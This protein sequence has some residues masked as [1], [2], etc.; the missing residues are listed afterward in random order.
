MS[1]GI[2]ILLDDLLCFAAAMSVACLA[3]LLGAWLGPWVRVRRFPGWPPLQPAL[4]G[5]GAAAAMFVLSSVVLLRC[6]RAT[7][8]N[9]YG[10]IGLWR[11]LEHDDTS[12]GLHAFAQLQ[13][14]RSV[15]LFSAAAIASLTA[16]TISLVPSRPALGGARRYRFT[17]RSL[18][19]LLLAISVAL[20]LW[21]GARRQAI[22]GESAMSEWRLGS[23][24]TISLREMT[25]LTE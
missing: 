12:G 19:I 7:A 13:T 18:F 2:P 10:F 11:M 6:S 3:A 20:G 23:S 5:V 25:P 8:F 15:V 9:E 14:M 4:I 16:L 17:L 21:I 24:A 1:T 22:S